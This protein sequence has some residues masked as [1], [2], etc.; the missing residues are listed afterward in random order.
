MGD[1]SFS[2]LYVLIGFL[3]VYFIAMGLFRL[4]EWIKNKFK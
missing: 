4:A 1:P 2:M 3:A